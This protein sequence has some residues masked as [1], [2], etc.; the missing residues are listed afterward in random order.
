MP[1]RRWWRAHALHE[2]L[3]EPCHTSKAARLALG[4]PEK[5]FDNL[6][7]CRC[8]VVGITNV[9]CGAV[10]MEAVAYQ[11]LVEGTCK[12]ICGE[13]TPEPCP[14]GERWLFCNLLH[15][16]LHQARTIPF[17]PG[18]LPKL[19]THQSHIRQ[20]FSILGPN[21]LRLRFNQG[22]FQVSLF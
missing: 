18:L 12:P 15:R 20:I 17:Q 13:G 16:S 11:A 9:L 4:E 2:G 21:A 7:T 5:G 22:A 14:A 10:V 6:L 19:I 8:G 3:P 1:I